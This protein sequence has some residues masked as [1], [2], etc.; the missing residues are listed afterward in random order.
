MD[1]AKLVAQLEREEGKRNRMYLDTEGNYTIGIGFNL[2]DCTIPDSIIYALLDYKIDEAKSELDRTLPWWKT[3]NEVRQTALCA[4]MFQLGTN[5]LLGFRSA[6]ALL[7][8]SRWDAAADAFLDSRWA[9]EQCPN[10]AKR[11]TDLIRKGEF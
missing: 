7:Q 1:R 2:S 10:R 4:M 8:A 5:K 11:V 3:L 6:L 9:K